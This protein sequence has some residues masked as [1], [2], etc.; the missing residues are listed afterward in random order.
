MFPDVERRI[1]AAR[2]DL[3]NLVVG[4]QQ[5]YIPARGTRLMR[6]LNMTWDG[7]LMFC[8]KH[9]DQH[10]PGSQVIKGIRGGS[11]VVGDLRVIV[12]HLTLPYQP[13]GHDLT[14]ANHTN[15]AT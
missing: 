5:K 9:L 2:Q 7:L 4:L 13:Q 12:Q 6:I 8:V 14:F 11:P 15:L 1:K 10:Q 3:A